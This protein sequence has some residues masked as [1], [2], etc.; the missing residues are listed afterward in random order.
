MV[1]EN[2]GNG[3]IRLLAD[4][5][6]KI[7]NK[8]RSFFSDFIYLGKN[9]SPDNYEE[10]G[11]EIWKHFI[12]E[13]NPDVKELQNI[14]KDLQENVQN[15]QDDTNALSESQLINEETDN[16][17]MSAIVDSDE[18]HET[19]TDVLL[20]AIDDLY[21]QIEP[22]LT[23]SEELCI[24]GEFESKSRINALGGDSMVELYVVMIQRG[25]KTIEQVPA[26]YR[27]Q[28]QALLNAVE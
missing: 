22:L 7:T 20:C 12:E 2:K 1:I 4:E 18:K 6:K 26:R 11:R 16:I 14:A 13:E 27:E 21:T 5:G 19:L 23:V 8:D 25:L 28:V 10:V 15:L 3:L 17:I 9:D 24:M